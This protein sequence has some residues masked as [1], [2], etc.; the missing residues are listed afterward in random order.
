MHHCGTRVGR[1]VSRTVGGH[2]IASISDNRS[3]SVPARSVDRPV[4]RRKHN[5]LHRHIRPNGSRFIRG[6]QVRHPRNNNK[7]SNDNRNRTD[8]SNRNRSR[9]IFRVS[10]SR[11]LSLLFRSLTLPGLGRGRRHRLA[12][13][14]AR[15]TNCATGNIP[16]GVDIIHSL[17]GSL[18]QHATVATNGQQRLRTLRRGLTVV[19]GDRPTRLLRRRHLHGRVTRLH[20]G[21]RHIPFVSAFSLHCGGCR[22]QP[23]PSD[24]TIVFYLV[25]ISNSVSRSAGSVTGRFCVL[26]CLFLDEACGGIRIMCVH[27]RA[28]TGRISRRRFFCSRRANNAVISDTLGLVSRMIGRHCG[29]TR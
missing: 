25:S 10:G 1:S 7:N 9:F 4:F 17:R 13:C 21:V 15:Q 2:S 26:L 20:T 3:M 18:T 29:P 8:R 11:C 24:R 16:T 19:D 12:R 6:S 5:N 27:R 23:S 22:G 28:R 14:G